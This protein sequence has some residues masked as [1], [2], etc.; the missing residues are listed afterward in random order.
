MLWPSCVSLRQIS[1]VCEIV[2]TQLLMSRSFRA[3]FVLGGAVR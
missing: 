3:G 1:N 2:T